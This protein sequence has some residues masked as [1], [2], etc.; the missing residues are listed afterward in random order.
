MEANK[1]KIYDPLIWNINIVT[2]CPYHQI[3]LSTNCCQCHQN[4][5][6]FPSNSRHGY[7]P[8]CQTWLGSTININH[9]NQDNISQEELEWDLWIT[10]Q[11]QALI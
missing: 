10:D 1:Q 6:I 11:I 4:L 8:K 5:P 2:I 7:C 3:Y 9:L